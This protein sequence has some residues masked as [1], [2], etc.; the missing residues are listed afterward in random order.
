MI[1]E[2][3]GKRPRVAEGAF[4]APTAALI[5]DVLLEA[6]ANVWYGAVLRGDFGRIVIRSGSSIQDNVVVHT[7]PDAVTEVGPDAVIGH[8][9]VVEG[10]SIG[11]S[12]LIGMN[13]TLLRYST[14]GEEAVVAAGSVL[15]EHAVVPARHLA[16]GVPAEIKREIEGGALEWVRA[17]APEYQHMM[18]RH[19][20]GGHG[21]R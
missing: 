9:A 18:R 4:V 10:C 7:V 17:A 1:V 19:L 15:L 8:G 3:E 13:A 14:V 20:A 12:A 11:R 2:F 6:G 16:A 21:S 5:G